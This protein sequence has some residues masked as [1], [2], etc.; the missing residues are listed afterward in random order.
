MN[1][2]QDRTPVIAENNL[3]G[4]TILEHR[5]RNETRVG[6]MI[7]DL[8]ARG[9]TLKQIADSVSTTCN[10]TIFPET[11]GQYLTI[12]QAPIAGRVPFM[13]QW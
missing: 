9:M 12:L 4:R 10:T 5:T 7:V 11:V 1:K 6:Q 13:R 3:R 8:N 2:K